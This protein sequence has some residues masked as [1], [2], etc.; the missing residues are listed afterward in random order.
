MSYAL[1]VGKN[2]TAEGHA[3]LAG[4]GDE[5]SSHWLEIVPKKEHPAG[6]VIEVG[7]G[8]TADM[9]G[10]RSEIPQV[11]ETAGHLRVS[12]S[13]Y[14]GVPAPITNGGLNQ[15]GVAVRD[16]WSDS[17]D[18][19]VAMTPRDQ[20]GPNYSDLAAIVLE[21]A[22]TAREGVELVGDLI[23]KYGESTYG[24]NSHL[25]ADPDEAWVIIQFAGGKGLWVA[26][27]LGADSIR[28]SRPGYIEVVPVDEP[29]HPDYLYSSNF[30]SFAKEQEWYVSGEFDANKIYGDGKGRWEGVKW[31]EGEMKS[32]A[33]LAGKVSL[34]D[35]IWAMRTS[36]LTGDTAGY[37]Q[38]VPLYHPKHDQ[39]RMIWHAAIGAVAAPF[40][41]VFLGQD[42]VPSEFGKHRYLT[43]GE[44]H[45]FQD[46]RRAEQGDRDALSQVDQLTEASRSAVQQCKRLLYLILQ[47]GEHSLGQVHKAFED[48]EKQ[49]ADLMTAVVSAAEALADI[50]KLSEAHSLLTYFSNTELLNGLNM[51]E[52]LAASIEARLRVS[53]PRSETD[54]VAMFKQ[55]W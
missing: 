45:R 43:V 2:H 23:A 5:P 50:G 10:L 6:S 22:R 49:V 25:I 28:V 4:Y 24:G 41:P 21:R 29:D 42:V 20:S 51:V 37:G 3:W 7:V 34:Q 54:G 55:I 44:S 26:E 16:V 47:D 27:R 53:E 48:R 12:Y 38:I 40:S 14:K 1:Y 19:L 15:Y 39:L 33:G 17:R 36:R 52:A 18:E 35:V 31:I 32:R 30:V 13:Y 8:P 9:P 11:R 46:A